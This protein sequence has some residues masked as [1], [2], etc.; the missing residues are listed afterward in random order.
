SLSCTRPPAEESTT[1]PGTPEAICQSAVAEKHSVAPDAVTLQFGRTD[2][3]GT[4]YAYSLTDGTQGTC[5]VLDDGT[6]EYVLTTDEIGGEDGFPQET[7]ETACREALA[8]QYRVAP[9]TIEL[10]FGRTDEGGSAFAYTL[11]NG[12][13]GTCRVLDDGTIDYLEEAP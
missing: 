4:A 7:L 13:S 10:I 1:T 12:T 9:D 5:R 2:E 8:Q 11:A 3:G 6:I